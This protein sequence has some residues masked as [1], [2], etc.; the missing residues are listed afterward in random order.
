MKQIFLILLFF[1]TPLFAQM[2]NDIMYVPSDNTLLISQTSGRTGF[3]LGGQYFTNYPLVYNYPASYGLLN[4]FGIEYRLMKDI[5]IMVGGYSK[6]QG[7]GN[8]PNQIRPEVWGKIRI[9]NTL[10]N[11][12]N[13]V[14]VVGLVK[15]SQ[16]FNYGLGV[17]V[18]W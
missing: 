12:V 13:N 5:S 6:N 16:E 15:V 8:P 3:Y 18:K 17:F 14:D 1:T 9:F 10:T 4:R 2:G 7:I 11:K